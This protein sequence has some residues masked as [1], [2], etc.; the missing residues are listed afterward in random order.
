MNYPVATGY[1]VAVL[2]ARRPQRLDLAVVGLQR[3]LQHYALIGIAQGHDL[4]GRMTAD[5]VAIIRRSGPLASGP[6]LGH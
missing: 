5:S 3:G 2:L 6:D 1:L 4:S